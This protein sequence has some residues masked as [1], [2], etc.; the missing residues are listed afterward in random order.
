MKVA[1]AIAGVADSVAAALNRHRDEGG[2]WLR[3]FPVHIRIEEVPAVSIKTASRSTRLAL[4][5]EPCKSRV[6]T[7]KAAN[8]TVANIWKV[9]QTIIRCRWPA[10]SM[11][12]ISGILLA[13][14]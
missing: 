13:Q 9:D 3:A 5:L 1:L 12:T 6:V 2:R 8:D 10:R 11:P 4:A 7:T 14:W